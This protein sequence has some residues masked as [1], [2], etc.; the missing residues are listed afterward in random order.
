MHLPPVPFEIK[1]VLSS[2]ESDQNPLQTAKYYPCNTLLSILL[3]RAAALSPG[4]LQPGLPSRIRSPNLHFDSFYRFWSP[5][6]TVPLASHTHKPRDTHL[7][8]APLHC[9]LQ[10]VFCRSLPEVSTSMASQKV[11]I[12]CFLH[13][14]QN[15]SLPAISHRSILRKRFR[16]ASFDHILQ[17]GVF[18]RPQIVLLPPDTYP[19]P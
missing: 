9:D 19:D 2:R 18:P 6:H 1:D 15:L 3:Q 17:D 11:H 7:P 16:K 4:M 5:G 12:P 13:V 10:G 14:L 8:K